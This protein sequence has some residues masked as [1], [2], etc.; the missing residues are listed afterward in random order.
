MKRHAELVVRDIVDFIHRIETV[1]AGKTFAGYLADRDA[2]DI[3]ERN[4]EKI[5]EATRS[6]PEDLKGDHVTIPWRDIAQMG[7]VLRH[8]YF[9]ID[10]RAV[11][12]V[13]QH[14][15]PACGLP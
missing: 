9:G 3:V 6:L 2:Q 12:N 14:D 10:H 13:V 11:W 15:L 5:S 1:T 7:N 4:I 8:I